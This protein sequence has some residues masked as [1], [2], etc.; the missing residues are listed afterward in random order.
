MAKIILLAAVV[1][2]VGAVIVWRLL[3]ISEKR[4]ERELESDRVWEKK[5]I[6]EMYGDAP[7]DIDRELE[8][9]RNR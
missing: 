9:E 6:E 4:V 3:D 8:R 5:Q 7:D 1:V 2:L